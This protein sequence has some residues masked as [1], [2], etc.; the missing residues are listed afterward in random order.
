MNVSITQTYRLLIEEKVPILLLLLCEL[1]PV[2]NVNVAEIN[3]IINKITSNF[4]VTCMELLCAF[5]KRKYGLV[6]YQTK[7][8]IHLFF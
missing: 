6:R 4:G 8:E 5:L 2:S 3:M 1:A 7:D